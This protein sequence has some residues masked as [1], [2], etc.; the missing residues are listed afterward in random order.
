MKAQFYPNTE[1]RSRLCSLPRRISEVQVFKPKE[2][3]FNLTTSF[4]FVLFTFIDYDFRFHLVYVK[5]ETRD[6]SS[7]LTNLPFLSLSLSLSLSLFL[8]PPLGPQRRTH[9]RYFPFVSL[10]FLRLHLTFKGKKQR[11]ETTLSFLRVKSAR[12]QASTPY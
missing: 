2:A 9:A 7:I 6:S 11:L 12:F 8:F 1:A 10:H 4:A 3:I 5:D